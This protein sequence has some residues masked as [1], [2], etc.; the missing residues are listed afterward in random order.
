M[1][2][3]EK[4]PGL[5]GGV[6][7]GSTLLNLACSDRPD[8]GLL[9]G[10]YY[11]WVGDSQT[12]KTWI[13]YTIFAEAAKN[14]AFDD[15]EF[16]FDDVEGGAHFDVA[17]YF[18]KKAASRI[19][20]PRMHKGQPVNSETVEDFYYHLTDLLDQGKKLIYILDSQ[21]ALNS[22]A[23]EKKFNIK[24][25]ASQ[26]GKESKGSY[27]D[28]KAK[29]H[30]ENLRVVLSKVRAS[31]S[32]LI[33]IS[34]TRDNLGFGFAE[35]TR[36]GGRSLKFYANLEIWSSFPMKW[37]IEK[38]IRGRKRIVG[39]NVQYEVKKNRFTG[40]VG[41]ERRALVPILHAL[42]ID[43]IGSCVDFLVRE[44]HWAKQNGVIDAKDIGAQ[45]KRSEIIAHVESRKLERRLS[46]IVGKVW[47]EIEAECETARKPRYE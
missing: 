27:G 17:R 11:L 29:Y 23:S 47:K 22:E 45:G 28:G 9:K 15:Y 10:G 39:V 42:G 21:D 4:T 1:P 16:V 3:K 36:S 33:I 12:G 26:E 6:S 31:G 43:D 18:G 8:I 24:K 32:I 20:S 25:K 30:S 35:K 14:P 44:K 19:H 46:L 41:K 34:Q 7:T 38:M 2:D 5:E 40:K 13:A 37:K